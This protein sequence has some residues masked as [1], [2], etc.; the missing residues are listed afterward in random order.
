[1]YLRLLEAFL[2]EK[3]FSTKHLVCNLNS[4]G[5]QTAGGLCVTLNGRFTWDLNYMA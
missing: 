2:G 4:M 5:V 3:Q 1:M